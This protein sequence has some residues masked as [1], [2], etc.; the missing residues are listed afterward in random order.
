MNA[1][2][3]NNPLRKNISL[4]CAQTVENCNKKKTKHVEFVILESKCCNGW[5]AAYLRSFCPALG[6]S[7][8]VFIS[9][10]LIGEAFATC[11]E[12]NQKTFIRFRRRYPTEI[13]FVIFLIN[14]V[15][16]NAHFLPTILYKTTNK[17]EVKSPFRFR[18]IKN[19]VSYV[20]LLE[21]ATLCSF[22]KSLL[23]NSTEWQ[24]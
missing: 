3:N 24:N 6:H 17:F 21:H 1:N 19:T 4:V 20:I 12:Q 5:L 11:G 2:A 13:P 18:I 23:E 10:L 16:N 15:H 9:Q 14:S 8:V 7:S 22:A